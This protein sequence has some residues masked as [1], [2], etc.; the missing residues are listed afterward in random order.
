MRPVKKLR[1]LSKGFIIALTCL[2]FPT[3]LAIIKKRSQ[4]LKSQ[5]CC[6]SSLSG[7]KDDKILNRNKL[8]GTAIKI[9]RLRQ[10]MSENGDYT[11]YLEEKRRYA[12]DVATNYNE[13][14]PV[15]E[16][17]V[18]DDSSGVN[19]ILDIHTMAKVVAYKESQRKNSKLSSVPISKSADATMPECR[20]R[21][22]KI[23][24]LPDCGWDD[25]YRSFYAPLIHSF[26]ET[27]HAEISLEILPMPDVHEFNTKR[28]ETKW[29]DYMRAFNLSSYDL[30][31]GHGKPQFS[32]LFFYFHSKLQYVIKKIKKIV[33]F[34]L[35][36]SPFCCNRHQ[37]RGLVEVHGE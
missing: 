30:V 33:I 22:A 32:Y 37:C 23:A 1:N 8:L 15:T 3:L 29:M 10:I 28:Y 31:V 13:M 26:N 4:L 16:E 35:N 21:A 18:S 27:K 12:E 34:F 2:F 14:L 19:R 5:C 11:Q 25:T 24:F 6:R 36:V 20:E 7:T 17:F 9:K